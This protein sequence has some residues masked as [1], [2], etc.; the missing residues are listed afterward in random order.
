MMMMMY[1]SMSPIAQMVMWYWLV[2]GDDK[3]SRR[4]I[5]INHYYLTLVYC[6][7]YLSAASTSTTYYLTRFTR[8]YTLIAYRNNIIYL[9]AWKQA[10]RRR[11]LRLLAIAVLRTDW[12][13]RDSKRKDADTL[14][15]IKGRL[16][17]CK[18]KDVGW[19]HDFVRLWYRRPLD[20]WTRHSYSWWMMTIR[21]SC[22]VTEIRGLPTLTFWSHVTSSVT[23]LLFKLGPPTHTCD[24]RITKVAG[25]YFTPDHKWGVVA[26]RLT[27]GQA[28]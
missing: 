22:T 10:G 20:Q 11:G 13:Q 24:P 9:L 2:F 15:D 3:T 8:N 25:L 4:W 23:W 5:I 12:R 21:R 14:S 7:F 18:T 27:A 28:Y 26:N 1:R 17:Q 6:F 19:G 16:W